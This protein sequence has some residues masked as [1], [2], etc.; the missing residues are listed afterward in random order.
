MGTLRTCEHCGAEFTGRK[1]A[2]FCTPAHRVAGP[3]NLTAPASLPSGTRAGIETVLA[4]ALDPDFVALAVAADR[5]LYNCCKHCPS[6]RH[7]R[8][9]DPCRQGCP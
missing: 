7:P 2:R 9:A 1:D 6:F 3:R 8:H 4:A 5:V